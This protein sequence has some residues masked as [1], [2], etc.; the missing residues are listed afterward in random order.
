VF[1]EG[2]GAGTRGRLSED[3]E[4]TEDAE[5]GLGGEG[6]ASCGPEIDPDILSTVR[7]RDDE[8]EAWMRASQAEI[9]ELN[10]VIARQKSQKVLQRELSMSTRAEQS[11]SVFL[12]S[13]GKRG[14][15]KLRR[16][17]EDLEA[18]LEAMK[19]A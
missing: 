18:Q 5:E 2:A 3:S 17:V 12:D 8:M 11:N 4:G 19:A 15:E 7:C 13:I 14:V 9:V 16:K 6:G 1:G 10:K